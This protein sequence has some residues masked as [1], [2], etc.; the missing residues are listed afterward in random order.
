MRHSA[1]DA[2]VSRSASRAFRRLPAPFCCDCFGFSIRCAVQTSLSTL[3]GDLA[4]FTRVGSTQSIP[5]TSP[6]R[7]GLILKL[8]RF[9]ALSMAFVSTGGLAA[10]P[11]FTLFHAEPALPYSSAHLPYILR[12]AHQ[13]LALMAAVY[14]HP[15]A[16]IL[17][18][19]SSQHLLLWGCNVPLITA[20]PP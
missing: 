9:V 17:G 16:K 4:I 14:D 19:A 2:W 8:A 5:D 20:Q 10:T 11:L 12:R 6:G 13:F 1:D 3:L 7:A 18:Y 15:S